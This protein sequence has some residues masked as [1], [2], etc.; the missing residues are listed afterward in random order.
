MVFGDRDRE[1]SDD[2][3]VR[4]SVFLWSYFFRFETVI[5]KENLLVT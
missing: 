3:D 1:S 2:V 4:P 5:E